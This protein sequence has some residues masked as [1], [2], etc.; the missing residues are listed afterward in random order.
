MCRS[1][2]SR[3]I[4]GGKKKTGLRFDIYQYLLYLVNCYKYLW[5]LREIKSKRIAYVDVAA[6][7]GS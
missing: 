5:N 3:E 1:Q 2:V 7:G 4:Y 6:A